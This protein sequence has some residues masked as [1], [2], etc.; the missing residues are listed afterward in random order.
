VAPRPAGRT[1]RSWAMGS[2]SSSELSEL[3]AEDI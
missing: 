2:V 1:M 3:S